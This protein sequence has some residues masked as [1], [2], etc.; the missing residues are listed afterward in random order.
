MLKKVR[1][2]RIASVMVV[3][4]F[5]GCISGSAI[6]TG[7]NRYNATP[8]SKSIDTYF[9]GQVPARPFEE[10]GIVTA[11]YRSGTGF[12]SPDS[13]DVLPKLHAKAREL[14]ADGV[15]VTGVLD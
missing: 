8:A 5:S 2:Q 3:F 9:S 13:T 12:S 6:P 14:G 15:I 7:S 10:I 1:W 11:Q 4:A